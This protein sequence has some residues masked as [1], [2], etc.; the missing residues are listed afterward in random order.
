MEDKK[1]RK[2]CVYIHTN[3]INNKKYVGI[4]SQEPEKRWLN[5]YGYQVEL[6]I[7]RAIRKYGWDNFKHEIIYDNL[8]EDE[9]KEIEISL[10]AELN[11]QDDRYGYNLTAGGDGVCGFHHSEESKRKM[12]I[13]KSGERHPNYNKHLSAETRAKIGRAHIGNTYAKGYVRSKEAREKTGRAR[14]KPVAM[15][16]YNGDNC[17]KVF[18]SAKTVED[19]LGISRKNISLCCLGQRPHAGGYM[20][21]FA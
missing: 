2:W 6:K 7:G 10:I 21:K 15:Y 11:T 4:T 8:S 19:T 14:M 12:S 17:L 1:P 20:W 18:D 5:G 3:K 16:D 13:A 9:A